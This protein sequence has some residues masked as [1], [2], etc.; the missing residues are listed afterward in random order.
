LDALAS[1]PHPSL[2]ITRLGHSWAIG[3]LGQWL[4]R[5]EA[6]HP[7]GSGVPAAAAAPY[8]LPL[9]EAARAWDELGCPYEAAAA[10]ASSRSAELLAEALRRFERLGARPAAD[11]AARALRNLGLRAPRRSTLSHPDGLTAREADVLGLLRDQ[12]S[13]AQIAERLRISPKTVD[14]HVSSILAKLGVRSRG[15]AARHGPDAGRPGDPAK[16]R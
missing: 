5:R 6:A 1:S 10:L 15:E 13:N 4:D 9:E 8:Q 14:H 16:P 2:G 12:L 7:D 11:Q 3:E